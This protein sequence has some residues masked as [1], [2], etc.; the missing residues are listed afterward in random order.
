VKAPEGREKVDS[1]ERKDWRATQGYQEPQ[2]PRETTKVKRWMEC[3]RVWLGLAK[4]A[5]IARLR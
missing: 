4:I 1:E 5:G 2:D 3:A